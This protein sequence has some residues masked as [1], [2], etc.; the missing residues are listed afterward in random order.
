MPMLNGRRVILKLAAGAAALLL[1]LGGL[2]IPSS[3]QRAPV[4]LVV[5]LQ[6]E[7]DS[8]DGHESS[9]SLNLSTY[10]LIYDKLVEFDEEMH[11][12]PQLATS[13]TVSADG[14]TWTFKLRTGHRF[15]DGVPVNADAVKKSLD[16]LVAGGRLRNWFTMITR[17]TAV[18]EGTVTVTTDRPFLFLPQR[19]AT[20][21]GSIVHPAAPPFTQSHQYGAS[22]VG[23]GPFRFKEWVRGQRIVLEKNPNH[24]L[25]RRSNVD[26]IE[27]RF[28]PDDAGRA[29]ALETGE[30]D[31]ALPIPPQE[32]ERLKRNAQISVL[33]LPSLRWFGLYPNLAKK[34][35]SDVRVRHAITH[36]I[37]KDAIVRTAMAG[38]AK[39]A[40]SPLPPGVWSYKSFKRFDHN[41]Q[42]ARQLLTEAG[43]PNGFATTMW[44][45]I[46]TYPN[47]QQVSEAVAAMLGQV[48][49]RVRLETMEAG[50]WIVLLRSK[51][52]D[53]STLE[54]SYYGFGTWTGEPDYALGLLFHSQQFAPAGSNRQFYNNPKV[55]AL[56]DVG[57]RTVDERQRR[58][59]Y[60]SIQDTIWQDQPWQYLFYGNQVMGAR[61]AVRDVQVLPSET[62]LFR[63]VR[64]VR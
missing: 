60:E 54:M 31:F 59:I 50:R 39:A 30:I 52:P 45:P 49:I 10:P 63:Q 13:W 25:A 21:P 34:P 48:G 53:E 6:G 7:P 38:Y 3:A 23:S 9:N 37:D 1:M 36:A 12:T 64:V 2:Q 57:R 55:D 40:D 62:V 47:A 15:H 19:L 46:G 8:L 11:L 29:I 18:D 44:V 41:P 58:L 61:R 56:L 28:L 4:R 32:A 43:Y 33:N 26:Q 24:W 35:F 17:V 51:G 16:R 42:R 20:P 5:G 22:P 14:L 27:F